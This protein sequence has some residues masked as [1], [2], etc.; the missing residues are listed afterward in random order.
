MRTNLFIPSHFW[1]TCMNFD[2]LLLSA[3]CSNMWKNLYRCTSTFSAL[4]NCGGILFKSLSY[5]YEVVRTNFSPI[6]GLFTN[7]TENSRKLWRHL[8]TKMRT[9]WCFGKR[10]LSWKA[11]KTASK[12]T[13][14]P[15]HNTCLNYVPHAQADQVRQT[16][17][18][19]FAPTTGARSSI[20]PKLCMLIENVVTKLTILKGGNHF[21]IQRSFSYRGENAD[22]GHWCTD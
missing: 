10:N 15:S 18:T 7:L 13:H 12:S 2:N 20:S 14:K 8:A 16:K 21:L 11:L 1:T 17:K 9:M 19:I 6:F 4:N 22:F 5:L 3:L